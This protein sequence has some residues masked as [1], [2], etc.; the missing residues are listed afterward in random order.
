MSRNHLTCAVWSLPYAFRG[1]NTLRWCTP[2]HNKPQYY[3]I[4]WQRAR[5]T[6]S[7][8]GFSHFY[9]DTPHR[10]AAASAAAGI[11]GGL[12][13]EIRNESIILR[14]SNFITRF[15]FLNDCI[16]VC[17][18]CTHACGSLF[19][20]PLSSFDCALVWVSKETISSTLSFGSKLSLVETDR[21]V[22]REGL[23]FIVDTHHAEDV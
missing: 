12:D 14:R 2:Q 10:L 17:I 5:E 4:E 1:T 18:Y 13:C 9:C 16:H 19:C 7:C 23:G 6:E 8:P 21:I 22:R 15:F 20:Q 3:R 11:S